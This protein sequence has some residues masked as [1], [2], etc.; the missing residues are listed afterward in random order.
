MSSHLTRKFKH[1][2]KPISQTVAAMLIFIVVPAAQA[3]GT[4]AGPVKA[5]IALSRLAAMHGYTISGTHAVTGVLWKTASV[6]PLFNGRIH[7]VILSSASE[8]TAKIVTDNGGIVGVVTRNVVTADLPPGSLNAVLDDASVSF[9]DIPAKKHL[10]LD[11]SNKDVGAIKVTAGTE[12]PKPYDGSGVVL[13]LVDT[14]IDL[15]HPDFKNTDGSSRV[16]YLW[17]QGI[18]PASNPPPD[19]GFGME[20]TGDSLNKG[21]CSSK[22]IYAHGTHVSGIMGGGGKKYRGVAPASSYVVVAG[23][24]RLVEGVSYVF[25]RAEILGMPAVLNLS[26]G[27]H[28]GPHDGT[29]PEELAMADMTKTPGHIIVAAAGN[30]GADYMHLGYETTASINKTYL[31]VRVDPGQNDVAFIDSWAAAGTAVEYLVGIGYVGGAEIVET[32]FYKGEAGAG[33]VKET[34]AKDGKQYSTVEFDSRLYAGNGKYETAIVIT[35]N[36]TNPDTSFGNTTG[37]QYYLK[38]RGKGWFDAWVASENPV[39]Q[40]TS[41]STA[42]GPGLKPGDN[43]RSVG[44]PAV[45]PQVIAAAAYTTK[46]EWQDI[47]SNWWGTDGTVGD[48]AGFSSRGPS[49]DEKRTGYKPEL[50]APGQVIASAL[51][52]WGQSIPKE[53]ELT[54][55]YVIMQGTSMSSPHVAGTVALMLQADPGLTVD[56]TRR[57]LMKTA[58]LGGFAGGAKS[59]VWGAGKLRA[60]PAVKMALGIGA[61]DTQDDCRDGRTCTSGVCLQSK[62]GKCYTPT[63]CAEGLE[64]N[65][66]G[67]CSKIGGEGGCSCS[68]LGL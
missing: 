10:R 58:Q 31:E 11:A 61:C 53:F 24:D 27:W 13:G 25:K 3:Q 21:T 43:D 55:E 64:C 56:K 6:P 23:L 8:K 37:Y 45:S 35:P 33:N 42:S 1:M 44:M 67:T 29:S 5:G 4:S 28:D 68:S 15:L 34:L 54:T 65:T 59:Y 12:L 9:M 49:A 19:F 7:V 41:F 16:K 36:T 57:I 18:T 30:E 14:G 2:K 22:D 52:S 48:I 46:T 62:G 26:L 66:G 47:E 17:D 38:V 32:A 39:S 50:S 63:D 60:L 51:S 40:N 20:C